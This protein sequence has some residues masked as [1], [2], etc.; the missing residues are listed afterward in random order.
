[1]DGRVTLKLK[2]RMARADFAVK[3]CTFGAASGGLKVTK[4]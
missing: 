2:K 1:M 3:Y 4:H